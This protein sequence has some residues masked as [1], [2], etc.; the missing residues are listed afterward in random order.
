MIGR[1]MH[2][3]YANGAGSAQ[4]KR[5]AV[6]HALGVAGTSRNPNTVPKLIELAET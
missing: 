3:C 1:Q 6:T 4:M 2:L 5:A